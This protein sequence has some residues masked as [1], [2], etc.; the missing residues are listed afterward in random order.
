M[1]REREKE[2]EFHT[3]RCIDINLDTF[4]R[5]GVMRP[6]KSGTARFSESTLVLKPTKKG[7]KKEKINK[8]AVGKYGS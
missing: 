6:F 8:K 1:H 2:R 4:H 3:K 5:A 7:G